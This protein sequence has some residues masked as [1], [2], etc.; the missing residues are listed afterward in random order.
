M[1]IVQDS[2][3]SLQ[4]LQNKGRSPSPPHLG[5]QYDQLP[6]TP[7]PYVRESN[8]SSVRHP[9]RKSEFTLRADR[10]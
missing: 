7:E 6:L 10:E 5:S 8:R 1:A 4:V 9:V 3:N 2:D